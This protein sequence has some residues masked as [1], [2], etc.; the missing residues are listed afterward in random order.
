MSRFIVGER[1]CG[2]FI[3]GEH[4]SVCSSLRVFLPYSGLIMRIGTRRKLTYI[5]I[6]RDAVTKKFLTIKLFHYT[7]GI[8]LSVVL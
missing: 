1:E 6:E 4:E 8:F 7:V 5:A 3:V 2:R